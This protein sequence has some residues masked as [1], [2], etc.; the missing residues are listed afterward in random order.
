MGMRASIKWSG[1]RE[2]PRNRQRMDSVH[3]ETC[4]GI[5]TDNKQDNHYT[6]Q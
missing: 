3:M 2:Q 4:D 6:D 1:C 5:T